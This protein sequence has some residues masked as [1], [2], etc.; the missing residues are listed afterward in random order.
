MFQ[1]K[2]IEGVDPGKS[3]KHWTI[4]SEDEQNQRKIQ[5][6]HMNNLSNMIKAV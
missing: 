2:Y 1:L 3:L 4:L 5:H 6:F